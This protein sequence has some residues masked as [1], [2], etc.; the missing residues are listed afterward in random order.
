MVVAPPEIP[1][2][3]VM[4]TTATGEIASVP[5]ARTTASASAKRSLANGIGRKAIDT[6]TNQ[7]ARRT[8]ILAIDVMTAIANIAT[9][10]SVSVKAGATLETHSASAM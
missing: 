3:G 8:G 9:G 7:G 6:G 5:T 1:R 4:A 10:V 2:E